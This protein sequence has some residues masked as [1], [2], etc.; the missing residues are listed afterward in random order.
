ME[1]IFIKSCSEVSL[2]GR[3]QGETLLQQ[4]INHADI[5]IGNR[6]RTTLHTLW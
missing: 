1:S 2:K 6:G 5:G 3:H 4:K